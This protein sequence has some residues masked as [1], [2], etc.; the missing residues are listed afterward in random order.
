M[1]KVAMIAVVTLGLCVIF[2]LLLIKRSPEGHE[3]EEGFHR[4]S[5]EAPTSASKNKAEE[6]ASTDSALR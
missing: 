2:V 5:P 3:D 4:G 6:P 1:A